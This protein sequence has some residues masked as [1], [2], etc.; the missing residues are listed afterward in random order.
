[1]RNTTRSWPL[2]YGSAIAS[3]ALATCVRILLDPVLG[4]RLPLIFLFV[5]VLFTAWYGGV[6]PS[7]LATIL[8]VLSAVFFLLG[9]HSSFAIRPPDSQVGLALFVVASLVSILLAEVVRATERR[10][11]SLRESEEVQRAQLHVTLT[12]I[13]DAVIVSDEQGQVTFL[14][15]V[16]QSLTGW[17]QQD[18]YLEPLETVFHIVNEESRQPVEN[19]AARV[20]REGTVIGLGN[21]TLL[22]ARDGTERPIDDSAAP[23]RDESGTITGV[24]LVFRDVT[25]RR[26]LERLQRDLNQEL[27]RQVQERTAALRSSE[28]RFRLLVEGTRDY[29]I[30][31]LDP[32]GHIVS[33]NPGAE[34]IKQYRAEEIIGQHFCRFY[35]PEDVQCGKPERELKEAVAQGKYEEE[36]WRVCKDGSRFWA[37]VVFTA[38]HDEAGHLRGLSKITRDLTER[39]QAEESARRL[40]EEQAAR[41]AAEQAEHHLRASEERFRQLAD[42]MP[43]I[44]FTAGPDGR[45]DYLNRRWYDYTGL[46]E[47]EVSQDSWLSALHPDDRERCLAEAERTTGT[48]TP[49]EME[50][51][52]REHRTMQYRWH[53]SR[54]VPVRDSEGRIVRWFGTSTDIHD[55]KVAEDAARFLADASAI[56]AAVVDYESTLQK[57]AGLAVPHFADWSAVDLAD[58]SGALRRLA[59]V[60]RDPKKVQ[61]AQDL[62]RRY[63]SDPDAPGGIT[64]VFRTGQSEMV[65]ELSDEMLIKGARD[66]E[67]LKLLRALGLRSYICV[68]LIVSD[69]TLGVLTFATAESGRRYARPDL[70]LAEDLAHRA[71]IAIVNARLYAELR[72]V[73]RLKDEFLAML[74]HELRNPLAPIRNAL[75]ILKLSGANGEMVQQ[76]RDMAERQVQHMARLLDDLLDVSR[77]SRGR[78]ELRKEVVDVAMVVNRSVEAMRPLFDERRHELSVSMPTGPLRV[79]TDPTRLEQV[80]TN[81]LNNAAKYTEPGGRV[82]LTAGREGD[83][84]VLRVRDTGIGITPDM[85]PRIFDLFVQAQ[86]RLDRSQG[87]VGIG[88]TLVKKLVEL[89]SGRIKAFSG[90][91][92]Q[93]SEFQVRI[94]ALSDKREME[95]SVSSE[96]ED[97]GELSRRRVLVV[98]DNV[99]AADSLAM[100]LRQAGQDVQTT[101]DGPSALTRAREYRPDLVILDIGMPGM[102]GY[103]VARRMREEPQFDRLVL[104]A[105]TGWGQDEDRLLSGEAGFDH[106]MVKPVEPKALRELLAAL[107]PRKE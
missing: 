23:I 19:P 53:L 32:Q 26:R 44:V 57:V 12:S 70:V 93:G 24:V 5:A 37:S 100:L 91:L 90:G 40:L 59:V 54:S 105:L 1:M 68:P 65:H 96:P 103:E 2:R 58:E 28:E 89:H 41:K 107:P 102:D 22:I 55:R 8:G 74:A 51:R 20:L 29:A 13:G 92:G 62:A 18:A 43:Q 45:T 56:L 88:L 10:S 16:A 47:G 64:H 27:E 71:A 34:R 30:F 15:P 31:M 94:P 104:V 14:N 66:E 4:D 25:E 77:I 75:H 83:E 36:G 69:K 106:H 35:P 78:I 52:F 6:G 60:H 85:L 11:A 101:Y 97:A 7:L 79:E 72:E 38:L 87:G 99:D 42:A 86:R 39:K 95:R 21:H 73:D 50:L 48:G 49:F 84:V 98:D 46:P 61:L 63:P 76:A 17:T 33:W 81:L 80:L 3:I 9:P 82:W 67:H